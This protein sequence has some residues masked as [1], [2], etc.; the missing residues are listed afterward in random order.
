VSGSV[1]KLGERYFISLRLLDP[2]WASVGAVVV[3]S[4]T[5]TL[6]VAGRAPDNGEV[7]LALSNQ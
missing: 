4:V 6:I 5:A 3:G 2:T 1:G 7:V